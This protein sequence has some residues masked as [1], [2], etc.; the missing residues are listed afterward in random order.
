MTES[1][2]S[3]FLRQSRVAHLAT[4]TK[5]GTPH[6][7]PVCFAFDGK[8]IYSSIDEKPK[9]TDPGRLRRVLNVLENPKVSLVV[10]YYSGNWRSLRYVLVNG[11]A[12]IL[13]EDT[14]QHKHA[15]KLLRRKYFQYRSMRIE[16]RPIIK[17]RP[18]KIVSWRAS[19]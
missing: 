3:R 19:H 6:V 2:A 8:I 17:I 9:R 4:S 13:R 1:W 14:S 5:N 7:V 12:S 16:K 15:V 18:L 10:D 11:L